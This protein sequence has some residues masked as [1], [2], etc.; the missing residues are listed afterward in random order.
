M[1]DETNQT[2]RL[3]KYQVQI[4]LYLTPSVS[5]SI[6][7]HPFLSPYKNMHGKTHPRN[8]LIRFSISTLSLSLSNHWRFSAFFHDKIAISLPLPCLA[9]VSLDQFVGQVN[10]DLSI[11][12]DKPRNFCLGMLGEMTKFLYHENLRLLRVPNPCYATVLPETSG[13]LNFAIIGG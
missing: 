12:S 5:K 13:G 2:F 4:C 9:E 8:G 3:T 11:H 6:Y 1:S 7:I 10:Q